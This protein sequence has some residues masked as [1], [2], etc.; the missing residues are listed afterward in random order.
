VGLRLGTQT[1]LVDNNC[2]ALGQVLSQTPT[3]GTLV[4]PGSA[5]DIKLGKLPSHP[6]P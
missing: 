1:E 2:V 3:A 4:A 6:C 5:V